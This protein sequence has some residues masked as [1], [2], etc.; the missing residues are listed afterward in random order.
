[1]KAKEIPTDISELR[2]KIL[3]GMRKA[4]RNLAETAAVN[5]E[6]LVIGDKEGNVKS[7]PA[8][9]LLRDL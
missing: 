9:E 7:V 2:A 3:E 1:M 5:N 8:K 6:S 4:L